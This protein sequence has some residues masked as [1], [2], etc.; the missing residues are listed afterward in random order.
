MVLPTCA[1]P[2]A[3]TRALIRDSREGGLSAASAD[4]CACAAVESWPPAGLKKGRGKANVGCVLGW[5]ALF[6]TGDRLIRLEHRRPAHMHAH[7]THLSGVAWLQ[8]PPRLQGSVQPVCAASGCTRL[9]WCRRSAW[10]S[11]QSGLQAASTVC[12][13]PHGQTNTQQE[14]FVDI[15]CSAVR[16][17]VGRRQQWQLT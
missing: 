3:R 16:G 7:T 1:G 5:H 11:T 17:T 4:T 6:G 2:T 9:R 12:A 15:C 14:Q 13:H 8:R 10:S